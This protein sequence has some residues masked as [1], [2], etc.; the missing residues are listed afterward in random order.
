MDRPASHEKNRSSLDWLL[1]K[2]Q[3]GD[4]DAFDKL[5]DCL[6]P[7]LLRYLRGQGA[8]ADDAEDA[9]G[10]TL[11]IMLRKME[12]ARFKSMS[13]GEFVA[14]IR[15]TALNA[16]RNRPA[17]K[18]R[19]RVVPWTCLDKQT[20]EEVLID[21]P[22]PRP[23]PDDLILIKR[24]FEFLMQ[25]TEEVFI[26]DRVGPDRDRG[27]MER[28]AFFYFYKDGQTQN[29]IYQIL[30]VIG[31]SF[32]QMP[33]VTPADLNN[34]LSMGR[35]LKALVAHLAQDHADIMDS[36]MDLHLSRLALPEQEEEVLRRVYQE[37]R[38]LAWIAA[39]LNLPL[40]EVKRLFVAG[41]KALID[42][43]ARTIKKQLHGTRSG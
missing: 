4:H 30:T 24:L 2:A 8:T 13:A 19:G 40:T 25:Q 11:L 14:Y 1:V 6:H 43:L 5:T 20:G 36:L 42:G 28:L 27:N 15:V 39:H 21:L 31:R 23:S 10:D 18:D 37:K 32:P 35:S 17:G 9:I 12:E 41:R 16:W 29:E 38:D 3:Q 34:W 22:D 7:I 33:P 26:G